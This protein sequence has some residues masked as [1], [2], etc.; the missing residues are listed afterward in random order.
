MVK[1]NIEAL[2][3]TI[4][5]KT[6]AGRGTTFTLKLPLTLAIIDG[7]TLRVGC[8]IYIVPLLSVVESIQPRAGSVQSVAG[9]GE[10]VDVRGVYHPVIRLGDVLGL[11][12]EITEPSEAILVILESEGERVA[13]MVDELLGQQQVVIKSLEKNFK[14]VEGLSGATILGDGTVALILD[15]RGLIEL[16]RH[17]APVGA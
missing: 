7:L 11:A 15:V 17:G 9:R 16:A 14:K 1:R 6:E 10:V 8:G 2:G 12:P 5:I 13:V 3:G 4:S